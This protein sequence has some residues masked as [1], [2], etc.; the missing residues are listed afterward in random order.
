[1]ARVIKHLT[2]KIETTF[3]VTLNFLKVFSVSILTFKVKYMHV[4]HAIGR[5]TNAE[6]YSKKSIQDIFSIIN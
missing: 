5:P 2:Q 4:F 6:A 1:M 3:I